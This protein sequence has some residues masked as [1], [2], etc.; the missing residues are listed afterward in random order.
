MQKISYL[1]SGWKGKCYLKFSIFCLLLNA[2]ALASNNNSIE[3]KYMSAALK[4]DLSSAS[5][6]FTSDA[7]N[8]PSLFDQELQKRFE[9]RFLS[10][11]DLNTEA[12][13]NKFITKL[14]KVYHGYWIDTLTR[15]LEPAAA[16]IHLKQQLAQLLLVSAEGNGK[17]T[18]IF[19]RVSSVVEKNG[20]HASMSYSPPLHDLIIWKKETRENFDVNLTDGKQAVSVVFMEE[21]ASQGWSHFATL[22]LQSISGWA[23]T[24]ELYCVMWAYEQS[25]ER[26][27]VS[28]LQHEAR[29]FADYREFPDLDEENLEYRAKLTELAFAGSTSSSLLRQFSTA[30]DHQGVTAH[31]R[32]NRRVAEDMYQELFARQL[33]EHIDPWSIV[34]SQR[35]NE[36]AR[37]L[38]E[39]DTLSLQN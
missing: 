19:E 37:A 9:L 18:E 10:T 28:Y 17:Q 16:H 26:F 24:E 12:S 11:A 15:K 22:G 21:F 2:S 3:S 4:G 30:G 36:A 25:S 7:D 5:T 20:F 39:R 31:S 14:V 33:P 34:G 1:Y 23:G 29:H 13:E 35:A 27:R 32:A 8:A 6:I 38:L